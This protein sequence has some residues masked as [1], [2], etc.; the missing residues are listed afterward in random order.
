MNSWYCKKM[1]KKI[2]LVIKQQKI[3]KKN[4]HVQS[5][6]NEKILLKEFSTENLLK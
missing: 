5:N 6:N 3:E 2:T 4:S 1:K